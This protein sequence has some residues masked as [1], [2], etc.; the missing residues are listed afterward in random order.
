MHLFPQY[1]FFGVTAFCEPHIN[2]SLSV[3]VCLQ[4]V[5]WWEAFEVGNS[6]M[7]IWS[8]VILGCYGEC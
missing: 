2:I 5:S 4:V 6:G 3:A 8:Q 1:P 7:E